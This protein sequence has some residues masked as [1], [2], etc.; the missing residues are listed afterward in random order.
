MAGSTRRTTW[1]VPT[2]ATAVMGLGCWELQSA[3]ASSRSF[4]P[5]YLDLRSDTPLLTLFP[6]VGP[7]VKVHLPAGLPTSN[8]QF[9]EFSP[10][11]KS[12]YVQGHRTWD[13][14]T[15][16]E[17][18]PARQSIVR[19]SAGI[20]TTG[21]LVVLHQPE[22]ILVSGIANRRGKIECG[23]FELD[24]DGGEFRQL[25]DG[26][27][28]DCGGFISPDG[29]R[30]L[31]LLRL[32]TPANS[33]PG[34]VVTHIQV[35]NQLRVLDLRTRAEQIIGD[36]I[37]W[38]AWSPD[39]RWIAATLNYHRFVLIDATKTSNR[40]NLGAADDNQAVWSPDSKYLLLAKSGIMS[41]LS[42][43]EVIDVLTGKRSQIKSSH[44]K[45]LATTFGWMDPEA[46]R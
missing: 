41:E 14:I 33:Q 12:I 37:S 23:V 27:F 22:R 31:A 13:G 4:C 3:G 15:K 16:I 36:G 10:D 8:L 2:M 39:G 6:L 34:E 44:W 32:E 9:I 21:S 20:G 5:A 7:E 35:K 46:L 45:I 26:K 1:L 28:P 29:E 42:S 40:R 38:A 43:L 30:V 11:G 17:F 18:N 19:G 25:L 24:P